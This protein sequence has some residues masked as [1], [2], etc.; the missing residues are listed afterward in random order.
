M[1][2]ISGFSLYLPPYRVKLEDWCDWTGEPWAKVGKV[3]GR[4]FR[5]R[6]PEQ[7]VYCLA[8][9]AVLR[10]IQNYDI[11]PQNIGVLA[12]GTE[13]SAD[14][15]AGAVIVKGL[16]DQALLALGKPQI[17]SECEVP[18][19][20]HACLGGVYALKGALRYAAS[21]G[22]GRQAI[23][24]SADI[25]EYARGS[26]GEPTQGAGAVAMLV[27]AE[28]KLL[29]L[30]LAASG[31]ASSYRVVDFRKPF[32]RFAGQRPGSLGQLQDVPVFNGR[33]ST[34]C[35]VDAVR[36]AMAAVLGKQNLS[37]AKY[38]ES[39]DAVFMHRPYHRMPE[40][41]WGMAYLFALAQD[42]DPRLSELASEAEIDAAALQQELRNQAN[43]LD[44]ANSGL[45]STDAY[46]LATGLLQKFRRNDLYRE[47]ISDKLDLGA[48][49]MQDLGNLYTAALPAWLAAGLEEALAQGSDPTGKPWL[50]VGYGS[51][52]AAEAIP[53]RVVPNWQ[54][55]AKLIGFEAALSP[56]LDLDEDGYAAL[57]AG[58]TSVESNRQP[59]SEFVIE[60]V[61]ARTDSDY[62]DAGIAYHRYMA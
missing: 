8:A 32:T 52:D 40:N 60:S 57:H 24:V 16:V 56:V 10:L 4:S 36:S 13:S 25:A 15:S 53:M 31:S 29:E 22:A 62:C 51:G 50:A 59:H 45:L 46:P 18:E 48:G 54:H 6:G 19:Y 58:Y 21:D 39:L 17:S 33:Y 26:S 44:I 34:T 61:G 14:N 38:Y 20:K 7:D 3:V 41:G 42:N 43:V 27:E 37:W 30:D 23:V 9:N 12:L 28:P 35:Y 2:G 5:M 11:D 55:A 49:K 1:P 47:V